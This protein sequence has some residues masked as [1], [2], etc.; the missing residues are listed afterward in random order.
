MMRTVK[1]YK[2][3]NKHSANW[4]VRY[5]DKE[6]K[7]IAKSLGTSS[8][9]SAVIM[10]NKLKRK[11]KDRD[12]EIYTERLPELIELFLADYA[13]RGNN[14]HKDSRHYGNLKS[15]L[16]KLASVITNIDDLTPS[17][18][19]HYITTLPWSANTKNGYKTAISTF[20]KWCVLNELIETN[21][22]R[23]ITVTKGKKPFPRFIKRDESQHILDYS[24][25]VSRTNGRNEGELKYSLYLETLTALKTGMRKAELRRLR[26]EHIDFNN[27]IIIVS[28]KTPGEANVRAIPLNNILREELFKIAKINGAVFE[29]RTTPGKHRSDKTWGEDIRPIQTKYADLFTKDHK[30]VGRGWHLFRHT[31]ASLAVQSGVDIYKVSKWMGHSSVKVTEVYAHLAPKNHDVDIDRI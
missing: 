22:C 19:N 21:P 10:V 28:G 6:G 27:G 4:Y 8:A 7:L 5:T 9:K 23:E 30:G 14:R 3:K 2:F 1:P 29:S 31:F 24:R 18:L 11:M 25:E 16:P 13:T 15:R 26:W 17:K 12:K 20:C